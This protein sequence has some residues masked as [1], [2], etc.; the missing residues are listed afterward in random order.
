[1]EQTLE[2]ITPSPDAGIAPLHSVRGLGMILAEFAQVMRPATV[3]FQRRHAYP[4]QSDR[5]TAMWT[6]P[7]CPALPCSPRRLMGRPAART[8]QP[9]SLTVASGPVISP[10]A[11][12]SYP[13][14]AECNRLSQA[15]SNR[16]ERDERLL[17]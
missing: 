14:P 9:F 5:P 13:N 15:A 8:G 12:L 16:A 1:M 17:R 10:L 11:L 4:Q 3:P 6:I 7:D 2:Q